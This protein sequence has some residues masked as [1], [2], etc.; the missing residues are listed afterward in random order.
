MA[1]L[2]RNVFKRNP[3]REEIFPVYGTITFLVFSWTVFHIFWKLPSW[4]NIL[5]LGEIG[6]VVSYSLA[7]A[8]IES[9]VVLVC[10]LALSVILPGSLLSDKFILRGNVLVFLT[11]FWVAWF[12]IIFTWFVP[13]FRDV[14]SFILTS[15]LVS[16]LLLFLLRRASFMGRFITSLSDRLTVFLYIWLPLG[17]IGILVRAVRMLVLVFSAG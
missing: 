2:I 14:L 1:E 7:N 4:L 6:V 12:D 3:P 5:T 11:T 13:S 10:V 15:V 9:L 16:G 17:I 8:L